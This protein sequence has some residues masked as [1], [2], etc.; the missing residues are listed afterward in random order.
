V[1]AITPQACPACGHHTSSCIWGRCT[2]FVPG[3]PG[4]PLA[5]YCGCECYQAI[6]GRTLN[7]EIAESLRTYLDKE[8]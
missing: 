7:S 3:P 1:T 4:G 6:T 2:T 5:E 8:T